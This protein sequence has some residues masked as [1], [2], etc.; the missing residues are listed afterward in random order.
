M[1][2]A[3]QAGL[4][5]LGNAF[6]DGALSQGKMEVFVASF[7]STENLKSQW[8]N[9]ADGGRGVSAAFDLRQIRPPHELG[10]AVTF[11]PC[12]YVKEEKEKLVEA[13]LGHFIE[14]VAKLHRDTG[15]PIWAGGQLSD[16]SL[17]DEIYGLEFDRT[18]FDAWNNERFNEQLHSAL[19]YTAFD[20]LRVASHCKEPSFQPE[21][22]WRL[23]LPHTKGKPFTGMEIQYRG[24]HHDIP[25]LAHKPV[26]REAA[27][28]PD[29]CRST[30]PRCRTDTIS[31]RYIWVQGSNCS[32]WNPYLKHDVR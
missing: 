16:W 11:A 8:M 17:V 4:D 3:K 18:A 22:E 19:T 6:D 15:N 29:S 21:H 9:Y 13:A 27:R 5:V 31:T 2:Y 20:L 23:S 28:E 14:R 7:S 10:C 1:A 25:Y 24:P 32:V 30:L 12:L 26:L